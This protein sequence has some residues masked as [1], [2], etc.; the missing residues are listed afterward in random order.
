MSLWDC[1]PSV[2]TGENRRDA[3]RYKQPATRQKKA[4]FSIF[5][6]VSSQNISKNSYIEMHLLDNQTYIRYLVLFPGEKTKLL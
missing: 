4:C 2:I 5:S 3:A 1:F 6:L